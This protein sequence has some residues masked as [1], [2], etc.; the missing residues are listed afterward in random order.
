MTRKKIAA[1]LEQRR[2]SLAA[3]AR[4]INLIDERRQN[5]I[6]QHLMLQGGIAE[7]EHLLA[8][9]EGRVNPSQSKEDAPNASAT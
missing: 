5:L 4:E 9:P 3:C 7:L 1:V 2:Q 6:N 8:D